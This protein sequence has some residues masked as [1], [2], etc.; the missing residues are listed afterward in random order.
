[1]RIIVRFFWRRSISFCCYYIHCVNNPPS[2]WACLKSSK[3]ASFAQ[4]RFKSTNICLFSIKLPISV[5]ISPTVIEINGLQKFT[6]SRSVTYV[7]HVVERLVEEWS[8]F[9]HEIISAAV[10]QWPARLCTCVKVDGEHFE[11]FL[12]QLTNDQSHCF[13]GDVNV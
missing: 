9:D 4:L 2:P 10:T 7:D 3:L 6:V 1:M 5:K 12:W 11:H 13:T 8:R